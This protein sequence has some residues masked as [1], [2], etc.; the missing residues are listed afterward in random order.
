MSKRA[1]SIWVTVSG[2]VLGFVLL[3]IIMVLI[4]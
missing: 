1:T 2:G 4:T 3:M